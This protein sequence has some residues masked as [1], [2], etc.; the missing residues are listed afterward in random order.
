MQIAFVTYPGMTALDMVGPYEVMRSLPGAEVRFVWHK[1]GPITTDSGVLILGATHSFA[2]TPRPDIVLV[3]GSSNATSSTACD[4]Q[5]LAWLQ[6]VHPG[7]QWTASVCSGS[8]ILA[9]AGV[10]HGRK[11]TTHWRAMNLL[12][13]FGVEPDPDSR[14]VQDGKIVTAAGV[15]AGFDLALFMAAKIAGPAYAQA[16]QLVLEY[17]PRPLFDSGHIKK[18]SARTKI[19]ANGIMTK[20]GMLKPT[21]ILGTTRLLWDATLT[22]A[23]RRN[24]GPRHGSPSVGSAAPNHYAR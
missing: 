10:L 19:T 20:Q 13:L 12:K 23:R 3:P 17:D 11:A 9:A 22:R 4:R 1:P 8:V 24:K 16:L 2:E 18:A 15:S 21:E 14:I 6:E 7:T 5:L